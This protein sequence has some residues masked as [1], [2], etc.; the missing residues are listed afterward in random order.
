[1]PTNEPKGGGRKREIRSEE[2]SAAAPSPPPLI[3]KPIRGP[4]DADG[5]PKADRMIEEAN[6]L[7]D[8]E[9]GDFA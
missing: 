9:H 5:K 6:D 7:G 8:Q 3:K 4:V 1:M 2:V